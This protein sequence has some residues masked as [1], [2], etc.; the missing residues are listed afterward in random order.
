M[1]V[2]ARQLAIRLV[3][4]LGAANLAG[5]EGDRQGSA[6][7]FEDPFDFAEVQQL[8]RSIGSM[9][10][11]NRDST[12]AS[13]H[14]ENVRTAKLY[15]TAHARFE[16]IYGDGVGPAKGSKEYLDCRF[17]FTQVDALIGSPHGVSPDQIGTIRSSLARC[18]KVAQAWSGPAEMATFGNDLQAMAN[19]SMLVLSYAAALSEP[20]LGQQIYHEAAPLQAAA[21]TGK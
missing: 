21:K 11:A 9:T 4:A 18:R 10:P 14:R 3:V 1:G 6:P 2:N 8:A 7:P 12:I 19:G 15:S 5:C 17:A 16:A 20:D 13:L